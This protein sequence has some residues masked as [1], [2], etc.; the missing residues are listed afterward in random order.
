MLTGIPYPQNELSTIIPFVQHNLSEHILS[1]SM[2]H[3]LTYPTTIGYVDVILPENATQWLI[4]LLNLVTSIVNHNEDLNQ[5]EVTETEYHQLLEILDD[6]IHSVG[7]DENHPLTETMTLVG[8]LIKTY[9]DRNFPKL[10]EDVIVE[11]SSSYSDAATHQS[12]QI[13]TGFVNV[14]YVIGCLLSKEGKSDE[15]ISAFDLAISINPDNAIIHTSRGEAKFGLNDFIGAKVDLHKALKLTEKQAEN[16]FSFV[17][18]ERLK[19]FDIV[20]AASEYFT[21]S[22]F[23]ELSVIRECRIRIGTLHSRVDLVLCD[24]EGNYITIVEC[25]SIPSSDH[26]E[27]SQEPLKSYLCATD[28]LY[29]IFASSINPDSW[30]FYENLRHNRFQKITRAD[31]EEQVLAN[32]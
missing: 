3:W 13:D 2:L 32:L 26:I 9:E 1:N 27:S 31:F 12:G 18:K 6:L 15:A 14:L 30:V 10:T 23:A 8:E 19:K 29:G 5:V 4:R 21:D 16:E 24:A 11:T 22:K 25:K 20:E 17:I 28:T 7:E